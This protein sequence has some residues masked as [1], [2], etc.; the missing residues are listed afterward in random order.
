MIAWLVLKTGLSAIWIKLILLAVVLLGIRYWGNV[1][2]AK[3]EQQGRVSGMEF[4]R[5]KKDLEW[6]ERE[7]AQ[8]L[9]IERLLKERLS[10]ASERVSLVKN[11]KDGLSLI[12]MEMDRDKTITINIPANELPNTVLSRSRNLASSPKPVY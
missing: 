3:G 11:L 2:W 7:K 9:E 6:A 4:M 1:Q 5:K 12:R 8:K 10:L